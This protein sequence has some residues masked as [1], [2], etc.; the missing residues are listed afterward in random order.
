MDAPMQVLTFRWR[1]RFGHF[2]R[3][4]ANVNALSYP[5]PPRTAVL[6]LLGAILGLEKDALAADL[7]GARVAVGGAVPVRFWHRVKLRKDPPGALPLRV[8]ARSRAGDDQGAAEKPALIRQE[9]LYRPDFRVDVA[10]PDDP[11][12]LAAL[13]GRIHERRW[14]YTPCMGLSE[15]L[16]DVVFE[17]LGP[18]QPLPEGPQRVSGLC[19]VEGVRLRRDEH[20]GV[21]LL[22]MPHHVTAD[23]VF[24][25][26][27][28]YLE[29]RGRPIP[30][31]TAAAW[32]VGERAVVLA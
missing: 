16:A 13:A 10:L 22:R 25:H 27:A 23:R 14:H 9:W 31:T 18:A 15:L 4:E 20:L 12:R 28:Y 11:Q 7:A 2:L 5:V 24:T 8:K 6:G 26:A 30:V 19:P 29:H 3:A 21:H 1:A 17:S 32:Q